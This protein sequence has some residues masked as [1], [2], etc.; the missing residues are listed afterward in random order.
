MSA[1][2]FTSTV[3]VKEKY[4]ESQKNGIENIDI[5]TMSKRVLT[6]SVLKH[7]W[8]QNPQNLKKSK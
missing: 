6:N 3:L 8:K 1:K 5:W 2:V 4:L 7:S